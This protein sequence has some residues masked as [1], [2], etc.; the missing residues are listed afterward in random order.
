MITS[1]WCFVPILKLC[2]QKVMIAPCNG[3]EL[4]TTSRKIVGPFLSLFFSQEQTTW[5]KK[6]GGPVCCVFI[7]D[8]YVLLLLQVK[9]P[10]ESKQALIMYFADSN[11][12]IAGLIRNS[13]LQRKFCVSR[14][15]LKKWPNSSALR[16][17]IHL[18]AICWKILP[19]FYSRI[20]AEIVERVMRAEKQIEI[21]RWLHYLEGQLLCSTVTFLDPKCGILFFFLSRDF[22]VAGVWTI[23]EIKIFISKGGSFNFPSENI[24]NALSSFNL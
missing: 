1:I 16:G 4:Q 7:Y 9:S 12:D 6:I 23:L 19:S 3:M 14:N 24:Y 13:S 20:D 17:H 22:A 5:H 15:Q 2:V 11:I 18:D 21:E 10:L 8:V